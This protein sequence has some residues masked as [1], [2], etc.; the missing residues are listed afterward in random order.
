[1]QKFICNICGYPNLDRPSRD[2][3]GAPSF[4]ICQC[5]GGEFGYNDASQEAEVNYRRNWVLNGAHW[6]DP[7]LEPM[8][9]SL[10]DQLLN[11]DINLDEV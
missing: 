9:W 6:F 2:E 8:G 4:D 11:I 10:R 5:C 3:T 1:M 7:S